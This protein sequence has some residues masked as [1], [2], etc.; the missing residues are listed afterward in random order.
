MAVVSWHVVVLNRANSLIMEGNYRM[1]SCSHNHAN[2]KVI[3]TTSPSRGV[4]TT[5]VKQL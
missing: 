4:G 5:K 1:R 3:E 2:R